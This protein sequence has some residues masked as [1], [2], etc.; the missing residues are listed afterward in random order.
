MR[1]ETGTTTITEKNA[2]LRGEGQVDLALQ[3]VFPRTDLPATQM[4]RQGEGELVLGRDATCDIRLDGNDISRR[5]AVIRRVEG[6]ASPIIV[7]LESRN[8]V[9]VNSRAVASARLASGD[10][11]RLDKETRRVV[12]VTIPFFMKR[13]AHQKVSVPEVSWV[14]FNDLAAELISP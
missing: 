9:R 10:V 3:W 4:P 7:D 2:S 1:Q 13:A 14:P 12:G 6:D 11:L 5:H 8:G